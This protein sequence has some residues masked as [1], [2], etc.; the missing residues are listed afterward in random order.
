MRKHYLNHHT[1]LALGVSGLLILTSLTGCSTSATTASASSSDASVTTESDTSASTITFTRSEMFTD[2]DQDASYDTA[3][4][5]TIQF[6]DDAITC[7]NDQVSISDST[8]TISSGGTYILSGSSAQAQIIIDT[9]DDDKVQLVLSDLTLS[10]ETSAPIYVRNADKVFITL[11]DGSDNSL[12]T[13]GEFVQIDDNNIDAVIFSKEDLTLNGTG[14]LTITSAYG[15]GI[16][17]KDDLVVTGGSYT[18]T[19]ARHGLSGKDSVRILDGTFDLTTT[20]DGIHASNDDDETLGYIY[21][22]G[23][24]FTICSQDDGMHADSA[25]YIEDGTIDIIESYEGL[26]GQTITILDGT[27]SIVSSDDGINASSGSSASSGNEPQ[28]PDGNRDTDTPPEKR[29]FPDGQQSSD[30]T[31]SEDGQQ[32]SDM[33]PPEDGQQPSDMT[34]PED[35]QQPSDMTPP[36]DG[37]QPSD[38][39]P[40]EDG[41]QPS[42]MT[43]PEDGQQPSDMTPPEDGQQPSDMTPPGGFSGNG[44]FDMDADESCSLTISGGDI[45]I[46][47]GGDGIDSNGYFYMTGGNVFVAGPESNGDSALDYGISASIS[48][49]TFLATGYSGMAQSFSDDSEQ[50]SYMVKLDTMVEADS[51]T[52][53]L[54]DA[55]GMVLLSHTTNKSYNCVIV[56]C[57]ELTS[58]ATYTLTTGSSSQEITP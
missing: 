48:G 53:T 13:T 32:P 40:P 54:T 17:S 50:C 9:P 58:G 30:T 4:S 27:I 49:G 18:M 6:T 55:E 45:S 47:A 14:S 34:P 26:E 21:I 42:D 22:A 33:T 37:Q 2:R 23:G 36:E 41:Q 31:S 29:E 28:K 43:P 25:L 10:C 35:G 20:K 24:D 7:D 16:V 57:P 8:V 3:S 12:S 52:L 51:S 56:S 5:T 44:G 39:T 19:C 15:H 11:A 46:D 38:M 1:F